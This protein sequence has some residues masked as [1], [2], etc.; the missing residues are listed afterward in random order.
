MQVS[1]ASAFLFH[2]V[3]HLLTSGAPSFC[4]EIIRFCPQKK[5][6]FRSCLVRIFQI[7]YFPEGEITSP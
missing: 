2:L 3:V 7:R 4:L 5:T 6:L 1:C